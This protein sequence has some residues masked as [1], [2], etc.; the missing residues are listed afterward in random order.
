VL[1]SILID[2]QGN[3]GSVDGDRAAA[4]RYT[5]IRMTK[6]GSF[7]HPSKFSIMGDR[8]T[9]TEEPVA[10]LINMSRK[11]VSYRTKYTA[12]NPHKH[13][14]RGTIDFSRV[15]LHIQQ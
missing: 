7:L 11:G 6:L 10:A 14:F 12:G 5:E 3:F 1:R 9:E 8:K 4:M 2:G 13:V 15:T